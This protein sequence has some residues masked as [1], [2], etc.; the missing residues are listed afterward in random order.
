MT[1]QMENTVYEEQGSFIGQTPFAGCC[2]TGGGVQGNSDIAEDIRLARRRIEFTL[3]LRPGENVCWFVYAT[4]VS[5][6]RL[7]LRIVNKQD[8]Y[9]SL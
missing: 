6:E 1:K 8:A 3:F 2:L 7:D 4:P 9:L 5:V